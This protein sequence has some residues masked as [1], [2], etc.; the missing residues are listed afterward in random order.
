MPKQLCATYRAEEHS[1]SL[2]ERIARLRR[3]RTA[4]MQLIE[5]LNAYARYDGQESDL[6]YACHL[7][8]LSRQRASNFC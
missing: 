4:L 2:D 6:T 1:P 8:D 7:Y 3:R 5:S